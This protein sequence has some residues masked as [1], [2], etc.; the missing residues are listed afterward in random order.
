MQ[1]LY[2]LSL[3]VYN[4]SHTSVIELGKNHP[5]LGKYLGKETY[6]SQG[7]VN[8]S[9]IKFNLLES[10]SSHEKIG[11]GNGQESPGTLGRN[12]EHIP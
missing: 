8:E 5:I 4:C 9:I 2:T 10:T 6:Q 3:S 7:G 11:T 1:A 12:K